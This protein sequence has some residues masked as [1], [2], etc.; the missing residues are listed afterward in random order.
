MNENKR[1]Y[2]FDYGGK[3][4]TIETGRMAKQAD[5]SVLISCNGTQVLVTACSSREV[6]D[7]QDFFLRCTML[8]CPIYNIVIMQA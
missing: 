7:G 6:K 1:E 8:H 2:T 4:V 3:S 5:G